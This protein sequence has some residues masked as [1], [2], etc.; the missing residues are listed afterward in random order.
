MAQLE[1][2]ASSKTP[3]VHQTVQV[4]EDPAKLVN[5]IDKMKHNPGARVEGLGLVSTLLSRVC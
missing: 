3:P 5:C 1:A 4:A 2:S